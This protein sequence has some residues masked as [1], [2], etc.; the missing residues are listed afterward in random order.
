MGTWV[1]LNAMVYSAVVVVQMMKTVQ[2]VIET[3]QYRQID[4]DKFQEI[5]FFFKYVTLY[6]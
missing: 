5:Y 2:K 4:L 6:I 3:I 1:M